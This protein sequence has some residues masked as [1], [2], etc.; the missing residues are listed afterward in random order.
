M[1]NEFNRSSIPELE[2]TY[3]NKRF[4][5][6]LLLA[7]QMVQF[8]TPADSQGKFKGDTVRWHHYIEWT[9]DTSVLSETTVTDNE[10]TTSGLVESTNAT[11]NPYGAWMQVA[12]FT[13][14]TAVVGTLDKISKRAADAGGRALDRLALNAADEGEDSAKTQHYAKQINQVSGAAG[15]S[16][17]ADFNFMTSQFVINGAHGFD[18]LGGKFGC[19]VHPTNAAQLKAEASATTVNWADINKHIAGPQA[20]VIRGEAGVLFNMQIFESPLIVTGPGEGENFNFALALDGLGCSTVDGSEDARARVIIKKP[21]PND[22]YQP[23]DT[24]QTVGWKWAGVFRKLD[25]KRVIRYV[26]STS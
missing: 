14:D 18:H 20:Q 3:I 6:D 21:G 23:L 7:T 8:C 13:L 24:Y 19:V 1:A 16:V 26:A 12:N 2:T 4:L 15:T 5:D 25:N 11:M 17:A 10:L 22:T 9:E